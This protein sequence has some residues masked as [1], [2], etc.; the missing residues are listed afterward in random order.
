[1]ILQCLDGVEIVASCVCPASTD[2]DVT[3]KGMIGFIPIAAETAMII[4]KEFFRMGSG[5][6]SLVFKDHNG[7]LTFLRGIDSHVAFTSGF[8]FIF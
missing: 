7:V 1:M 3:A 6:R 4:R 2:G 5:T 8:P